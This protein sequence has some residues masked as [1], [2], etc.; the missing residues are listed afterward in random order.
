MGSQQRGITYTNTN[1]TSLPKYQYGFPFSRTL[2]AERG[3]SLLPFPN[4]EL[5]NEHLN[6]NSPVFHVELL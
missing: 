4:S 2:V 1:F 6:L 3:Y 5:G